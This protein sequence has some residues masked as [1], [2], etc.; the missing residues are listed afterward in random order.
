MDKANQAKEL[1]NNFFSDI[2]KEPLNKTEINN[3]KDENEEEYD[4][5][6]Y[7]DEEEDEGEVN[8]S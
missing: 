1:F 4:D 8:P 5:E 7:Y 6:Y 2:K 3:N